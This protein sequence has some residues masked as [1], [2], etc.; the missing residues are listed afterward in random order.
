M[1]VDPCTPEELAEW[2]AMS[3]WLT[4]NHLTLHCQH[5]ARGKGKKVKLLLV[6]YDQ[7]VVAAS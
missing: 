2:A 5:T 4:A 7:R 6:D 3:A 1:M